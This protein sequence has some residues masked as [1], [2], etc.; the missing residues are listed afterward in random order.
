MATIKASPKTI[1]DIHF[2]LG[3]PQQLEVGHQAQGTIMGQV[4]E[5]KSEGVES[6]TPEAFDFKAE[7]Q[8]EKNKKVW[9]V[10]ELK[11]LHIDPRN[12]LTWEDDY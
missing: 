5:T 11:A 9:K 2:Q 1:H 12:N 10:I 6:H 3:N 4:I 8:E 7:V